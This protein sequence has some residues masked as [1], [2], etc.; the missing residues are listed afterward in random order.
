MK[1][2]WNRKTPAGWSRR[3]FIRTAAVAASAITFP[4]CSRKEKPALTALQGELDPL[5]S[6]PYRGWEEFYRKIWTWDKV[7]RSTHSANCTSATSSRPSTPTASESG[8][9]NRGR[10]LNPSLILSGSR[11][12]RQARSHSRIRS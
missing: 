10:G 9:E 12:R 2:E 5:R 11:A 6:Y 7:V 1:G 8:K 3:D 4:G